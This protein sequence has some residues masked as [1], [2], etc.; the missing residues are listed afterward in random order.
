MS[1]STACLQDE[2]Q[3]SCPQILRTLQAKAVSF[4]TRRFYC[5]LTEVFSPSIV[6]GL[7]RQRSNHERNFEARFPGSDHGECRGAG[8]GK[9]CATGST[10]RRCH[11]GKRCRI[12][13]RWRYR[14][15]ARYISPAERQREA[16]VDDPLSRRRIYSREQGYAV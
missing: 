12:R 5:S 2:G 8:I 11:G 15:E 9:C 10:I 4:S 3:R 13:K 14:T 16:D 1:T 7:L 6:V